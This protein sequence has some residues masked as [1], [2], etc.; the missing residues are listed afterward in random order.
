[1]SQKKV[2]DF[3]DFL[4]KKLLLEAQI[5]GLCVTQGWIPRNS[6]AT[7]IMLVGLANILVERGIVK[8]I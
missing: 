2:S 4:G 8:E 5:R 1:M 3:P 6:D 7:A